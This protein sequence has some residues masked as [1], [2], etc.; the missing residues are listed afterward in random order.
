MHDE[1]LV[2][3]G[4]DALA[5]D[6]FN[7]YIS[8]APAPGPTQCV[9]YRTP[10]FLAAR[11]PCRTWN[12]PTGRLGHLTGQMILRTKGLPTGTR[13]DSITSE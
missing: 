4:N 5:S 8:G 11:T 9:G 3:Y 10:L 1:E 13:I 2:H 12:S 7:S 6:F